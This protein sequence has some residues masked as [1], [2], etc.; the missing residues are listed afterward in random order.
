MFSTLI[1]ALAAATS[2]ATHR[3]TVSYAFGSFFGKNAHEQLT[4][5]DSVNFN[6]DLYLKA[7]NTHVRKDSAHY[8]MTED[9]IYK[10]L[11]NIKKIAQ[12]EK[13][14]LDGTLLVQNTSV[15]YALGAYL[16]KQVYAQVIE[17]DSIDLDLDIFCKAFRTR[18]KKDSAHYLLND[19]QA[20]KILSDISRQNNEKWQNANIAFLI[21]N[22]YAKGIVTTESGLQYK[23]I[24]K[25][26]GA[27]PGN[28][29]TVKVH[30]TGTLINGKKFDSSIDRGEPLE[31][32]INAVIPGWTEVLKLMKVGS[33]VVAWIPPDLGYG[34]KGR[35]PKIPGNS[36]LVFEMELL[37]AQNP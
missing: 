21:K 13:Q 1:L 12:D 18:F 34:K 20:T 15:S 23:V 10:T 24:T 11:N 33:K 29:S 8:L 35:P 26:K 17:R 31:F 6:L 9:A 7:F 36:V 2:S 25:G 16:A 28:S 37:D 27:V 3:D 5:R 32:E 19:E 4:A 14:K 22:K 30:Y